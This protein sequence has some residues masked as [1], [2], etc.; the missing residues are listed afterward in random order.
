[1]QTIASELWANNLISY[2]EYTTLNMHAG[3]SQFKGFKVPENSGKFE[4]IMRDESE[5]KSTLLSLYMSVCN[6]I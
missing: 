5:K 6:T 3:A 1:M 4:I 2:N